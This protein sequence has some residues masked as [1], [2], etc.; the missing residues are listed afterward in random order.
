MGVA[1]NVAAVRSFYEAGPSDDD[2]DRFPFASPDIV[3]HVPGVNPVARDYI[4]VDEVFTNMGAAMQPL[5]EWAIT[6]I[7]IFGNRD[8]VMAT[9][10][11]TARRGPHRVECPG[12][13]VF[14]FDERARIV[15]AWGFV[16]DQD[17]LDELF[18]WQDSGQVTDSPSA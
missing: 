5:D 6:V 8:L 11:L 9:V 4:G 2:R 18:R 12:G 3:W 14:R 16:R 13:H 17:A 15:E 10:H 1:Q 7:D